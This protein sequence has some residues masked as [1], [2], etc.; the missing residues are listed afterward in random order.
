MIFI[1]RLS[2]LLSKN[3]LIII[4]FATFALAGC[5]GGGGGGSSSSAPIAQS[6]SLTTAKNTPA[7]GALVATDPEGNALTYRIV[8]NASNGTAVITDTATGAYTYT[9]N[10]GFAGSD[11]FTFRANDGSQ[12]SNEATISIQILNSAPVA[13]NGNLTV[14]QDTASNG[15]LVAT[16]ADNDSLVYTLVTNGNRGTAVITDAATGAYTYTPNTGVNGTDTIT[17]KANDGTTDS[18]VATIS[19]L[20]INSPPVAQDGNLTVNQDTAGNG[21]LVATDAENDS[22]IYSIVSNG[23]KGTA[24]ITDTATG[25]YTYTPNPGENG[26]DTFTFKANDGTSDSNTATISVTINSAP[27][28]ESGCGTIPQ[29]QTLMGQLMA[30]DSDSNLLMFNLDADGSGGAGPIF[31]ANGGTVT[32]TDQ[33]TG[34]F[35]YVPASVGGRGSDTFSYQVSDPDGNVDSAAETVIVDIKIMPF[36]DSIT[37]GLV[38]ASPVLPAAGDRVGYRKPLHDTLI[39]DGFSFDFVG[40]VTLGDNLFADAETESYGGWTASQLAF[41]RTPTVGDDGIRAWLTGNPADIVLVHAGTNGLDTDAQGDGITAILNEIDVWESTVGNPVT[42]LLAMII[43]QDPINAD[44]TTLN[45]NILNIAA[46][47]PTDDIV[48][49]DQ[50]GALVYPADLNDELHPNPGGYD[51][52]SGAWSD[53]L[54]TILDKCPP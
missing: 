15:T 49:V 26:D 12:D 8:N 42:V 51:K 27:V 46:S 29:T 5:G 35:D 40:S 22:L 28:A 47:R 34:A 25:A 18:N 23:S 24:V 41:G 16:D 13:Q 45:T 4:A 21:T 1:S 38:S 53:T 36:G 7:N 52:M 11:A 50:Q 39:T 54:K 31:T 33:T 9:P 6:G 30:S 14:N 2:N 48:I 10:P 44:V 3:T 37:S 32:L 19:I 43:D 17:F 20:I